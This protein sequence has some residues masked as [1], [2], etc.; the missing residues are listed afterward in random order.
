[1]REFQYAP[2]SHRA[3]IGQP[4][5]PQCGAAMWLVCIEPDEPGRDLRTFECPR[6]QDE[7]TK[8]VRLR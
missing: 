4:D 8:V 1:M 7:L 2:T 3:I 6:C 5:C